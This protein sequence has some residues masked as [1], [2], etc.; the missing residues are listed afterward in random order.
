MILVSFVFFMSAFAAIG[1]WA[2]LQH[3]ET[4]EDYL[5]AG[6]SVSPWVAGLSAM[7]SM[8][9]G[10]IF[11]GYIGLVYS[12]GI[13]AS[14]FFVGQFLGFVILTPWLQN[15]VQDIS[16]REKIQTFSELLS[17]VDGKK[18]TKVSVIV[19]AVT[20]ILLSLYGAAQL[21]AGGKALEGILGWPAVT[22]AIIGSCILCFYSLTGGIRASL[23]T[24]AVQAAIMICSMLVLMMAGMAEIGGF[25][26]LYSRLYTIDPKLVSIAPN[27]ILAAVLFLTG[28]LANGLAGFA[29]PHVTVRFMTVGDRKDTTK[30]QIYFLVATIA[31]GALAT[32]TALV[33]RVLMADL[34]DPELALPRM[35]LLLLPDV[36]VG[37]VLAGI[38]ASSMSTADSLVLSCSASLTSSLIPSWSNSHVKGRIATLM[39]ICLV[40][41]VSVW[42]SQ[43]VFSFI[44]LVVGLI[45]SAF[46]P[47]LVIRV[48]KQPIDERL[49]IAMILSGIAMALFWRYSLHL[50]KVVFEAAP[51]I[52]VGFIVYCIGRTIPNKTK[53]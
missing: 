30:S 26:N 5:L 11:I 1:L 41:V 35:S 48:L 12:V 25:K 34:G 46:G 28:W 18:H 4:M 13:Y 16:A 29:M 51:G 27:G 14:L 7:A 19:G 33:M 15:R 23:W 42:G 37:L 21:T 10:F 53:D 47:L 45:A 20:V 50:E 38:F 22:G 39:I 8:M 44:V 49:S 17:T 43:E 36:L 32:V 52:V 24:D 2:S 6:R 9:S 40:F 31:M 3:K